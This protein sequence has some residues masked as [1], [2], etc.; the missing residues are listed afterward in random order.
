MI[1][2]AASSQL[3]ERTE[4]T[5]LCTYQRLIAQLI[6]LKQLASQMMC[7]WTACV[8]VCL[9]VCTCAQFMAVRLSA[10]HFMV[11]ACERF[12]K[13]VNVKLAKGRL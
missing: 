5:E 3:T 7:K 9:Y 12:V 10:R 8:C 11:A 1:V 13:T 6:I 2:R 4:L